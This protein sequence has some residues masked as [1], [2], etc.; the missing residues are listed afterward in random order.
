MHTTYVNPALK[1]ILNVMDTMAHL[2]P[3]RDRPLVKRNNIAVGDVS[4]V[5]AMQGVSG[6][7]SVSVSF[8]ELV[9]RDLGKR[10]L[11]PGVELTAGLLQDL[12][13][14]MTNMIAGGMKGELESAGLRFDISLP[15]IISGRPHKIEHSCNAPVLLLPFHS[16]IGPFYVEITFS[17]H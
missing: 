15:K 10:M 16:E 8:P 13:G 11:P 1:A 6:Q 3:R 5:I 17:Q 12:T 7:G 14:E 9:I 4:S 2:Q